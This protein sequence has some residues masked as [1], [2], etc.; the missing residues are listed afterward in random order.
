[1]FVYNCPQRAL[2]ANVA[3]YQVILASVQIREMLEGRRVL[4]AACQSWA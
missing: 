2:K 1:L 3:W 4:V